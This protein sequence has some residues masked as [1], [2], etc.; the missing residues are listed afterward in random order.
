MCANKLSQ[1]G[2]LTEDF[3]NPPPAHCFDGP[4]APLSRAEMDEMA[5]QRGVATLR[6]TGPG[7]L[8]V[9]GFDGL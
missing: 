3:R 9:E 4:L 1:P 2:D 7:T 8:V 5:K 6:T